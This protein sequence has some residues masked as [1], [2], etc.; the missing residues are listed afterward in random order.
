[1]VEFDNHIFLLISRGLLYRQWLY[2]QAQIEFS[3]E[4]GSSGRNLSGTTFVGYKVRT[5]ISNSPNF[6]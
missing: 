3:G 1:M 2:T 5:G 6:N 4:R